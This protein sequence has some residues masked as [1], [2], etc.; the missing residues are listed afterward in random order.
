MFSGTGQINM[1]SILGNE[2]YRICKKESIK[3]I[4]EVGTW[5]GEG[6][7]I[8]VMNAIMEKQTPSILYSFEANAEQYSKAIT[9]WSNKNI[10][11][12][13]VL[14]KGVLH[15]DYA[16]EQEIKSEYNG[17]IPYVNEHYI[18]ERS[19]LDTNNLI[20]ISD[21]KDIDVI[22]LDGGEYTTYGDYTALIKKDPKVIILDDVVVYKCRKIRKELLD[23]TNWK[24]LKEDLNDRHGWSIFI[25]KKYESEF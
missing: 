4:V 13:L 25:N 20:D 15:R 8:C 21:L 11:N 12:K 19:M 1:N 2:I 17:I 24:L 6:S 10:N 22:I 9:F 3:N 7:T 16:T 18:P 23:N 5:N 14:L